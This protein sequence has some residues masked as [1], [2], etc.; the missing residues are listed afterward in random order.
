MDLHTEL[1]R[2]IRRNIK[3]MDQYHGTETSEEEIKE[4]LENVN[5]EIEK[6]RF[7]ISTYILNRDP[8]V[9][10][11]IVESPRNNGKTTSGFN[12]INKYELAYGHNFTWIRHLDLQAQSSANHF[13]QRFG[14][15]GYQVNT[16]DGIVKDNKNKIR[17]YF[18]ALNASRKARS[19]IVFND[20]TLGIKTDIIFFDEYNELENKTRG[21]ELYKKLVQ[22][23]ESIQRDNPNCL[24]V[25]LGNRDTPTNPFLHKLGVKPLNDFSKTIVEHIDTGRGVVKLVRV[26][27]DDFHIYR[28]KYSISATWA[29]L[30][31]ETSDY[32]FAG[33]YFDKGLENV[34][35]YKRFIHDSFKPCYNINVLG[36]NYV[37]GEFTHYDR[38]NE[39]C[40]ALCINAKYDAPAICFDNWA[41]V[42]SPNATFLSDGSMKQ[43]SEF[44]LYGY[45]S[46][47]LYFDEFE[48]LED[49]MMSLNKWK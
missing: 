31:D 21:S 45:K 30:D 36:R 33:K 11:I 14:D 3:D 16:M 28:P 38:P 29:S 2:L 43:I 26:G 5:K 42:L 4:H 46:R 23:V 19:G 27:V 13:K 1:E 12:Y 34:L 17:G 35:N 49:I 24:L 39:S 22:L 10:T 8:K 9:T 7:D 32:L 37:L 47:R 48:T 6:P 20:K 44:I 41:N 40:Y 18:I 25:M 15:L